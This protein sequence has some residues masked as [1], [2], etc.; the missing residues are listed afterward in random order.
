MAHPV[1]RAGTSA[2]TDTPE[3]HG[4]RQRTQTIYPFSEV[5]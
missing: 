1:N 2:W 3:Q 5:Q 4:T